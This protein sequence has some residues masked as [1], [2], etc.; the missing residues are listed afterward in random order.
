MVD[1]FVSSGGTA[2]LEG[3]AARGPAAMSGEAPALLLSP[4]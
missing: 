1:R 3:M 4:E 2:L